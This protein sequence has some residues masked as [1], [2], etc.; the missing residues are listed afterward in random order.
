MGSGLERLELS[1][2]S[3]S[4]HRG[5]SLNPS[6]SWVPQGQTR[7]PPHSPLPFLGSHDHSP[8]SLGGRT[9]LLAL[10]VAR[11]SG[12]PGLAFLTGSVT[13][14]GLIA[15]SDTQFWDFYCHSWEN[16]C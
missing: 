4:A 13:G 16:T 7:Y 9:T 11:G 1:P 8:C 3:I 12:L 2:G 14:T 10:S 6:G 5:R 15:A